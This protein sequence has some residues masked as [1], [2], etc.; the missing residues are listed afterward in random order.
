MKHSCEDKQEHHT[1][2][3]NYLLDLGSFIKEEAL[4]AR[5]ERDEKK[6]G[7]KE[8]S[9]ESGRLMAFHYIIGLMQQQAKAFGIPLEDLRLEDIDPDKHLL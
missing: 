7:S 8:Y 1:R 2:Y 5:K 9:L 4:G 3:K 6:R